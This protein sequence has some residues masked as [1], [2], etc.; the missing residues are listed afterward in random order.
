[1]LLLLGSAPAIAQSDNAKAPDWKKTEKGA[2]S[3]LQG[4]G[5]EIGKITGSS[6]DSKGEGKKKG[7]AKKAEKSD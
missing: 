1:M 4:M 7:H 6:K 5:Q 2:G 3:L